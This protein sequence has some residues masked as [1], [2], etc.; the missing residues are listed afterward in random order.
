MPKNLLTRTAAPALAVVAALAAGG[1]GFHGVAAAAELPPMTLEVPRTAVLTARLLV[2]L[3]V[4]VTCAPSGDAAVTDSFVSVQ[5][6]QAIPRRGPI[7][8]GSGWA[9]Q[10]V[11]DGLP[12]THVLP[13]VATWQGPPFRRGQALVVAN[14]PA[15]FGGFFDA[16][17]CAVG[18]TVYQVLRLVRPA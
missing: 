15:C 9:N 13:V 18:T 5:L 6:Q 11:C 7:A 16:E 8:L 1:F 14:G 3:P 17:H 4:Q 2:T 10:V 12:H